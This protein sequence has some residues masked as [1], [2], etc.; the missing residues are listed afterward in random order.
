MISHVRSQR[1]FGKSPQVATSTV[2]TAGYK[3]IYGAFLH[4]T[5]K[6]KLYSGLSETE[7]MAR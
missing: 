5:Q 3:Y 7:N 6:P 1:T 2:F 4:P